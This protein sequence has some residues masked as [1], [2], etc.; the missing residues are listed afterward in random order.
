MIITTGIQPHL[1]GYPA[2]GLVGYLIS[3]VLGLWLV[4]DILR[5]RR[6]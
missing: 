2:F 6:Y 5:S 1:F 4:I 3:G